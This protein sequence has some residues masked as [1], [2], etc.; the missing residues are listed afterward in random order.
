MSEL[1]SVQTGKRTAIYGAAA[2]CPDC[3]LASLVDPD[4]D[5]LVAELEARVEVE[6]ELRKA[7]YERITQLEALV[8]RKHFTGGVYLC[9]YCWLSDGHKDT[10][11]VEALG[12]DGE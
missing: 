4:R 3:G 1:V 6:L 2:T 9:R 12:G 7:A 8:R 11:P 10:C 5:A